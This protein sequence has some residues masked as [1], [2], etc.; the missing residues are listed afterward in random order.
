LRN[1][2][3][4]PINRRG[5]YYERIGLKIR[6]FAGL[7]SQGEKL[8]PFALAKFAKISVVYPGDIPGLPT[9]VI[10]ELTVRSKSDWSAVTLKLPNMQLCILNPTHTPERAR[11]T[12]MEEISHVILGHEPTLLSAGVDGFTRRSY[13]KANEQSAYGA[14]A[15]ALV[16]YMPLLAC[17]ARGES[18]AEI[19]INYEVS[20][21]LVIYRIK[22]TMLWRTYKSKMQAG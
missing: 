13:N 4:F 2:S 10:E 18:A 16:P 5:Q 21:D 11:V 20:E 22:I 19:A 7:T 17:I 8:D 6:N 9:E 1:T 15:A 3:L 12:L 14:G